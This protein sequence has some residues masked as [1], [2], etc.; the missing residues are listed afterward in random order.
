LITPTRFAQLG[1]GRAAAVVA[2]WACVTG[3]LLVS[4]ARAGAPGSG[5]APTAG[6]AGGDVAFYKAVV[7]RV[8][9]GEGYY[10]VVGEELRARHYPVRPAFTWRQP[11]YAWLLAHLPSPLVATGLLGAVAAAVVWLARAWLGA[12]GPGARSLAVLAVL[13]V[14]AAAALA[15]D[16]VFLQEAWAGFFITLSVCLYARERWAAA[17]VAG[18]AALA[19]RELALWP[20]LAAL[21]LAVLDRRWREVAAWTAGLGTYGALLAVH[22]AHAAAH[23]RPDD[24]ARGWVAVGGGA[25]I[26]ATA[27]WSPLFVALPPAAVAVALPIALLGLGGWRA[28]GAGRAALIV[29]GYLAAFAF[30]GHWF[31]DYWGAMYAPLLAFGVI[32][33]PACLR[34]LARSLRPSPV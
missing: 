14:S 6:P 20:C 5:G 32:A 26:I 13:A 21:A 12:S 3:W 8:R 29:F 23:V 27:R 19:F 24:L 28:P 15:P 10:D 25:F 16:Y 11:T 30:V 2:L 17:V 7:A 18:L 9:A 31:N 34:D 22:F 4:A 1:R 33:A